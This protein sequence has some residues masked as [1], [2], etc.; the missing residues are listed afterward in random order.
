MKIAL[1][2]LCNIEDF[3]KTDD[4]SSSLAFL[5]ENAIDY[6]DYASG[7]EILGDLLDGFHLALKDKDVELVWFVQGGNSLIRF[8]DKIDWD[9]VRQSNKEYYGLSDFTH[10]ALKAVSLGKVCYYGQ[11]LKHVKDFFPTPN[12]HKF[13]ADFLKKKKL[14]QPAVKSLIGGAITDFD[15]IK[16]AGGHSFISAVM[17]P[18]LN[19]DLNGRYLFFEHHYVHGEDLDDAAYFLN[20]IKLYMRNHIPKGIILGHSLMYDNNGK[21]I[22][23]NEINKYFVNELTDLE[24]PI[25]YVDH[26]NSI[27]RFS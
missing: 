1:V 6:V 17:L 3:S 22:E 24:L 21:S 27:I 26:F 23:I 14:G 9:L 16:I 5:K 8:L 11:G 7:R 4:Y 25:Y 19:L 2:N 18:N 15:K 13:I 10:F 12:S 20:A